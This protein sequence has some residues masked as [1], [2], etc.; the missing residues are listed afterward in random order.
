MTQIFW[1]I[2]VSF[3]VT[4][5]AA[6]WQVNPAD[7]GRKYEGV[8]TMIH[9]GKPAE[10]YAWPWQVALFEKGQP[11]CG[12]SL[13]D[14]WWI[15]TAA[16]CVDTN[17]LCQ[18]ESYTFKVGSKNLTG[19]TPVSQERKAIDILVHPGYHLADD[20]DFDNDIALF[21]MSEPFTLSKDY[22]VNTICLPTEDMDDR[23]SVGQD[24]YVTGW[25]LLT[26]GDV[27]PDTLQEAVVP[28][29]DLAKCNQSWNSIITE[30]MICAGIDDGADACQGDSGGPLVAYPSNDT[31]QFYE[32]GIVSWG[33]IDCGRTKFP[34]IYTRVTR[35]EEWI[36]SA[37]KN[38]TQLSYVGCGY[39]IGTQGMPTSAIAAISVLSVLLAIFIP[40]SIGLGVYMYRNGK[41]QMRF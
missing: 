9:D 22:K 14:P 34:G 27:K 29:Y 4:T 18:P 32:I 41:W 20:G 3:V 19:H 17:L 21:K 13:I 39:G 5:M 37:L 10:E 12:G 30:N 24:A 23:F 25:G 36:K 33:A 38:T 28:L 40:L 6:D 1:M 35:Y 2:L 16:H 7:C 15:M 26:G 31:S 8:N 11:V